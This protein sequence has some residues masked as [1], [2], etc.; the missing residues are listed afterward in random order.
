MALGPLRTALDRTGP[1]AIGTGNGT[2]NVVFVCRR[3]A[4]GLSSVL[5]VPALSRSR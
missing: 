1:E 3:A 2:R 5:K 4:A